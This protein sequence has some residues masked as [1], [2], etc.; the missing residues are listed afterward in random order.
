MTGHF[1]EAIPLLQEARDPRAAD[2]LLLALSGAGREQE[3]DSLADV[4]LASG[5]STRIWD[6][7]V[8]VMGRQRPGSARTLVDRLSADPRTSV[9][10][11]ARRLY[12][13]ALRV[14]TVDTAAATARLREAVQLGAGTEGGERAR[15]RLIRLEIAHAAGVEGLAPADDSL[16]TLS[17]HATVIGAEAGRLGATLSRVRSAADSGGAAIPQGDLRLFLAAESARDTLAAPHVAGELFRRIVAEWPESP[18]APK[19][20]LAGRATRF[21]LRGLRTDDS[22]RALRRQPVSGHAAG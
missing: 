12:E 11:K 3:T 5:D 14:A 2:E 7:L 15:L 20:L 1:D 4:M 8:V 13:E 17:A 18:Y 21:H 19:A 16:R 9:A 10:L 22:R 6:S